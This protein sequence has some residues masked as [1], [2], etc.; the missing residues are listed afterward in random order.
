MVFTLFH[1]GFVIPLRLK[2]RRLSLPAL[3]AGAMLPDLEIPF[4]WLLTHG[5]TDRM[6]L[7]SLFGALV[8]GVPLT[9]LFVYLALPKFR[10]LL[11]EKVL[12]MHTAPF[13]VP[14]SS[15]L[16]ASLSSLIGI[17]SHVLV[18]SFNYHAYNASPLL[19]PFSQRTFIFPLFGNGQFS[20]IFWLLLAATLTLLSFRAL[21]RDAR[22]SPISR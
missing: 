7:H 21:N 19:W 18:D 12:G 3:L 15:F 17:C 14:P 1:A 20:A 16:P 10:A 6:V 8:I 11:P 5:A 13:T 22:R 4:I 9:L 2:F